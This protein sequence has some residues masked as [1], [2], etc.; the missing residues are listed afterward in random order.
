MSIDTEN[1]STPKAEAPAMKGPREAKKTKS[2]KKAH[3]AKKQ[4]GPGILSPL[5]KKAPLGDRW[6][7]G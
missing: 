5:I 3:V 1:T 6:F 7:C 2:A 4:E